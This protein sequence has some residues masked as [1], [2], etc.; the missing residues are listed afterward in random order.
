MVSKNSLIFAPGDLGNSP[1]MP[2]PLPPFLAAEW[3][4]TQFNPRDK[5]SIL[6]CSVLGEMSWPLLSTFLD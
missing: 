1:S 3:I 5:G 6:I 4:N 2:D